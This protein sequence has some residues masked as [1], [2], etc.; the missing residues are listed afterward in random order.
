[1]PLVINSI[2]Y[3]DCQIVVSLKE[4]D[5]ETINSVKNKKIKFFYQ[6]GGGYGNS[7]TKQLQT[8]KQNIFVYSMPMVLLIIMTF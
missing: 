7:L 2:D 5:L 1:M 6:S 3:L 4:N 8:V